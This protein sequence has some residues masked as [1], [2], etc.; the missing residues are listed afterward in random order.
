MVP[1]VGWYSADH[2]PGDRGFA[3]TGFADQAEGPA[4]RDREADP[5][6]RPERRTAAPAEQAAEQRRRHVEVLGQP[7]DPQ[8]RPRRL[9]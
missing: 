4:A 1:R 5:V 6:D 9:A 2:E 8:E 7:L 3:A